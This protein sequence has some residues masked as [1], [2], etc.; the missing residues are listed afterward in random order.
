MNICMKIWKYIKCFICGTQSATDIDAQ[1]QSLSDT[2]IQSYIGDAPLTDDGLRIDGGHRMMHCSNPQCGKDFPSDSMFCP[3]CG[4]QQSMILHSDE[5]IVIIHSEGDHCLLRGHD[6]ESEQ[7]SV[8]ISRGKNVI[9]SRLYQWIKDGFWVG[10]EYAEEIKSFDLSSFDTSKVTEMDNMFS[11][12][13]SL[14]TLDLSGFDTS[15]VAFMGGMF[16]KCSSLQSLDLSGFNTSNVKYM[17]CM[18]NGCSSLE[19]LDL[20]GFDTSKVEF[21][22]W[23]FQDCESLETLDLSGF[24]TSKVELMSWMFQGCESLETLDLS[25]FDTSKVISMDYMFYGCCSLKNVVMKN[26]NYKTIQMI[27]EALANAGISPNLITC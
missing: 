26:C 23:M 6:D 14:E 17:S 5:S 12:C 21:M 3:F 13:R 27:S 1:G 20:S 24:N 25:G 15:S 9:S 8:R 18:F 22:S 16:N 7:K 4:N 11:G 10:G 19:T 2:P